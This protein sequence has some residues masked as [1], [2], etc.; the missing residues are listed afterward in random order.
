MKNLGKHERM[1]FSDTPGLRHGHSQEWE[2]EGSAICRG[3]GGGYGSGRRRT[4][5]QGLQGPK[6]NNS[7]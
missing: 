5:G 4:E 7:S 1:M 3:D 2:L 6:M